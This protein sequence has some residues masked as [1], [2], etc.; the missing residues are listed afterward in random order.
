MLLFLPS[1]PPFRISAITQFG[2]VFPFQ[3]LSPCITS[4]F[5]QG[6]P[7]GYLCALVS[8][9]VRSF[10]LP[11]HAQI[12]AKDSAL[13]F[14]PSRHLVQELFG[15]ILF[16]LNVFSICIYLFFRWWDWTEI[17]S[18]VIFTPRGVFKS[19]FQILVEYC[20]LFSLFEAVLIWHTAFWSLCNQITV[21]VVN[22]ACLVG[23]RCCFASKEP[24]WPRLYVHFIL[25]ST[26]VCVCVYFTGVILQSC[27][28]LRG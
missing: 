18:V 5:L 10:L 4:E 15:R 7:V 3:I 8:I 20:S 28:V 17:H 2:H 24:F 9:R 23:R 25:Y 27:V 1:S 16:F 14:W 11:P 13:I 26:S 22:I 19:C 6:V 12:A 21:A